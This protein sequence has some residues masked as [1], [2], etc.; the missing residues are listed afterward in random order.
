MLVCLS[1]FFLALVSPECEVFSSP[2][3]PI[4]NS[5]FSDMLF[6]VTFLNVLP[7]C[8]LPPYISCNVLRLPS[9]P[10]VAPLFICS[11]FEIIF[12]GE[13]CHVCTGKSTLKD[14]EI[15]TRG[16]TAYISE[17]LLWQSI[18]AASDCQPLYGYSGLTVMV[19]FEKSSIIQWRMSVTKLWSPLLTEC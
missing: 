4:S 15:V 17:S 8:L 14:L 11:C 6:Q 19:N 1:G 16:A 13:S 5:L 18:H 9:L 7:P 2:P 12:I 10:Y 3:D